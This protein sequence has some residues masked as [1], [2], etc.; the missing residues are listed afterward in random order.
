MEVNVKL[1]MVMMSVKVA[2]VEGKLDVRPLAEQISNGIA[3]PI[4]IERL[5]KAFRAA[6]LEGE[7]TYDGR[8]YLV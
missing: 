1:K 8:A 6:G 5:I 2:T 3:K 4:V 7:F